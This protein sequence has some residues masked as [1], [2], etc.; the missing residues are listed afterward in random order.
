MA[1]QRPKC[2]R[3]INTPIKILTSKM[4][5]KKSGRLQEKKASRGPT[6]AHTNPFREALARKIIQLAKTGE[7]DPERLCEG[8]LKDLPSVVSAS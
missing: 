5:I 2:S 6:L 1:G 7:R 3:L 4:S 8:A